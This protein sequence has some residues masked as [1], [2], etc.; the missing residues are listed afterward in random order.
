MT[1]MTCEGGGGGTDCAQAENVVA[2][3][4]NVKRIS[5]CEDESLIFIVTLLEGCD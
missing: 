2:A 4:M 3:E 1:G 5:I